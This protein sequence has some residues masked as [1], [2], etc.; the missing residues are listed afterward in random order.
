MTRFYKAG[1]AIGFFVFFV[2]LCLSVPAQVQA[3]IYPHACRR[4]RRPA[5]VR[6]HSR[7]FLAGRFRILGNESSEA[8]NRFV[9]FFALPALLFLS[10]ARAPTRE[11]FNLPFIAAY[12]CGV[13]V[14]FI[15]VYIVGRIAF[16]ARLAQHGLAGLAAMFANT[17]YM[18]IPLF[19]MAY[20]APGMPP[21]IIAAVL[22][23]AVLIGGVIILIELDAHK[24]GGFGR[25]LLG[26]SR[27]LVVN[28]LIVSSIAGLA[29]GALGLASRDPSLR[30]AT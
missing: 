24:S 25:V 4:Q 10:M 27:A 17:G 23:A 18:G 20:G 15:V 28:P 22:N 12:M 1:V 21:A 13:I 5:A 9:Y 30:S 16:P 3:S 29:W 14:V 26:V 8:L 7:G 6:N 2:P 19:L 11:V